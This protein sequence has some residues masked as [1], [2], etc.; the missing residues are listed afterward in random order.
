MEITPVLGLCIAG[1]LDQRGHRDCQ[2][3]LIRVG[4]ERVRGR[5]A[6]RLFASDKRSTSLRGGVTAIR[7]GHGEGG[8]GGGGGGRGGGE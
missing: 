8:G 5:L 1:C 6:Y 7:S 4:E 3:S 2:R